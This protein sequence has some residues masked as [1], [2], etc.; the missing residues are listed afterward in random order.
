M[1]AE[2][3]AV[4]DQAIKLST[5]AG[6]LSFFVP[7]ACFLPAISAG[8]LIW[9]DNVNL[10]SNPPLWQ[11]GTHALRWM[12]TDIE[13]VQ[14]YKPITWLTWRMLGEMAGLNPVAFHA[15]NILLHSINA[16][17]LFKVIGKLLSNG[18]QTAALR[19]GTVS[20]AALFGALSWAL[21]PL[22]VEPVAWISG[23][24]FPLSTLFALLALLIF[25]RQLSRNPGRNSY[26]TLLFFGFS[27]ISYPAA[28]ALP[29]L[30]AAFA[31]LFTSFE[32]DRTQTKEIRRLIHLIW[33]Y[34]GM[35]AL[36]IGAT[37]FVRFTTSE[38]F[39]RR[40]VSLSSVGSGTRI[41]QAFSIWGWYLEKTFL[42]LHL[43]PVYP[44]FWR[45]SPTGLRSL[46]SIF[47]LATITTATWRLRNRLPAAAVLWGAFLILSVPV[48]GLTE[49]PFS[50]ADRYTYVPDLALAILAAILAHRALVHSK[51]KI[52]RVLAAGLCAIVG[53]LLI[54]S[55]NQLRT[56]SSPV[57]FFRHAIRIVEPNPAA[58]DLHWRLGLH[59]LA[60]GETALAQN[61]FSG[62]LKLNPRQTDA[63]RY[64]RILQGRTG[65]S[66]D[67]SATKQTT[68]A[69]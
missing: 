62:A 49:I 38:E 56:W 17:L 10:L 68:I 12:F 22:R 50:P 59:Y 29:A 35:A 36:V 60:A 42:P 37:L 15:W 47:V 43:S 69:P 61:E 64:L 34:L 23:A 32:K 39:W 58:A 6:L 1:A 7:L 55:V 46:T 20:F 67:A 45:F 24:G 63:A 5:I 54:A 13:S 41:M 33:P 66:I 51:A 40:P 26:G 52:R 4:T 11:S 2:K 14:R 18:E 19:S 48:L 27:L 28:C 21:H 65:S 44:D 53:L 3:L 57:T 31:I 9:D 30:L 8:F 16:W 25:Q